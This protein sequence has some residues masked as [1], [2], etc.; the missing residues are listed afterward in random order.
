MKSVL[1][2]VAPEEMRMAVV[3]AGELSE[4]SLERAED[5]QIV[6]NIYKG[7]VQNVLPGMQAAFVD[8]GAEKNAFLYIGDGLPKHALEAVKAGAIHTGQYLLV[9]VVKAATAMKGP[10]ATTH[11]TLPGRYVVLTPTA[12]YVGISRRIPDAAE[13]ERLRRI[14]ETA[15]PEGI[16]L[17]VRTAAAGRSEAV[18]RRDIDYLV[19][20][21]RLLLSRARVSSVPTLLYRDADLVIRVVRDY[22]DDSF[23][24]FVVDQKDA[25]RRACDLLSYTSPDLVQRVRLYE[26]AQPLFQKYALEEKL[27][28]LGERLI[29]LRSGGSIVIDRTEALTVIDVNTGR[30]VGRTNLADTAFQMNLEA[31]GEIMRQLRLRD[32]GGIIVIDFID[33]ETQAQKEHI[34]HVLEGLAKRDRVKTHVVGITAL[35]LV[36]I[37]RKKS[38]R[39]FESTMY[40]E[41][42]SCAGRGF[43]ESPRTVSIRIARDLRRLAKRGGGAN[44][45][46]VQMHAQVAQE[47]QQSKLAA[48]LERELGRRIVLESVSDM[49]PEVYSILQA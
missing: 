12:E 9:Q 23:A 41:C 17:I 1:V 34:L 3:E 10:R 26:G 18:L 48:A 16:G 21:W 24:E 29:E 20:L 45:Y 8:I 36:E 35:G 22:L 15:R 39:N 6:G 13:R 42:P 33:M 46:L 44:G 4:I 43:I 27:K 19:N 28:E 25:Y 14:A 38:R 7:R 32:I 31:A 40:C 5:A 2:S 37:T 49:H 11:L 30:F 47:L